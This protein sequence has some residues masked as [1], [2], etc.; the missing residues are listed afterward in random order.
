MEANMGVNKMQHRGRNEYSSQ[1]DKNLP[2]EG[3]GVTLSVKRGGKGKE[4][5]GFDA[6][7]SRNGVGEPKTHADR[8]QD[9][10]RIVPNGRGGRCPGKPP[11]KEGQMRRCPTIPYRKK[12]WKKGK[13]RPGARQDLGR[14]TLKKGDAERGTPLSIKGD[15]QRRRKT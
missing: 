2:R 7:G 13:P 5:K 11:L 10:R 9:R 4:G 8:E 6:G 1:L 12:M 3:S 15:N 14:R